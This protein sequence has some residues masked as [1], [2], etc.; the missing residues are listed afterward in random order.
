METPRKPNIS[1]VEETDL[2]VYVWRMPDGRWIG[3]DDGNFLSIAAQKGDLRRVN[4]LAAAVRQFGIEEGAAYFLPGR[5]KINDEEYEEQR[6]RLMNGYV[7]DQYD[8][9]ALIEEM[10]QRER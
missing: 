1:V 6:D 9:P 5:R 7:P 3:D 4:E 2:G 10:K 8:I